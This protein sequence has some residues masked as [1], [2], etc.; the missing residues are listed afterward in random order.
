MSLSDK[1]SD[2]CNQEGYFGVK[3]KLR[4]PRVMRHRLS[5]F[6][7]DLSGSVVEENGYVDRRGRPMVRFFK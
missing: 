4:N 1:V 3:L 5:K 6:G 7:L 2:I